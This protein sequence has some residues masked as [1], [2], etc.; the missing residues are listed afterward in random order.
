MEKFFPKITKC[1]IVA[2][3]PSPVKKNNIRE[4]YL[5]YGAANV[6]NVQNLT[7]ELTVDV[8]LLGTS[9]S[10]HLLCKVKI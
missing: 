2:S 1:P 7:L 6:N 4:T 10:I 5:F 3:V 8:S 9:L